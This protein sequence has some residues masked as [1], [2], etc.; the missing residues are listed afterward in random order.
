MAL[1]KQMTDSEMTDEEIIKD[2]E[3]KYGPPKR[4]F[5]TWATM[6]E[7]LN[8][9]A[10]ESG[11]VNPAHL[12]ALKMNLLKVVRSVWNPNIKDNYKDGRNYLTI[13]YKCIEDKHD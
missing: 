1:N 6:C 10:N 5:E 3:N 4:C 7:T 2:R 11:N 12:Y 8:Q 9:Y 13:A